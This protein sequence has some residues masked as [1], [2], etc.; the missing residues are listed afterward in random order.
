MKNPIIW[1]YDL[2]N[3]LLAL[4]A[5]LCFVLLVVFAFL[6]NYCAMLR[7]LQMLDAVQREVQQEMD[8]KQ[9]KQKEPEQ[10]Q[11]ILKI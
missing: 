4:D 8:L 5:I 1:G 7:R 3:V 11:K 10:Q 2:V 6:M 9:L